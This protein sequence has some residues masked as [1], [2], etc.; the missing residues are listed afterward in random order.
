[1]SW[2]K[3]PSRRELTLVLFSLTV[4]ILFYN[5][6]TSFRLLGV[7][8][9]S[10]VLLSKFGLK[11]GIIGTDGRKPPGWRDKLEGQIFGDWDWEVGQVAGDGA[12]REKVKGGK[13]D[14]YGAIWLSQGKIGAGENQA[15][16]GQGFAGDAFLSWGDNVPTTKLVKHVPGTV[17][18]NYLNGPHR[19]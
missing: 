18:L 3:P 6:D 14:K 8:P 4:F 10:S 16:S 19:R 2:R 5:L 15:I 11:S 13:D 12:E 9:A 1:M 17:D 7:D